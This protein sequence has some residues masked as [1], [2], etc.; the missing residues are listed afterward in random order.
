MAKRSGKHWTASAEAVNP[1]DL[2]RQASAVLASDPVQAE[3]L[4][5][6]AL[7]A[8]PGS[9]DARSVLGA[10][11]RRK[12]D[13]SAA[14]AVL[15][16]LTAAKSCPW[17]V[18]FELAQTRVALGQSRAAVAPLRKVVELNPHWTP[19][20]RLLGDILIAGGDFAG[21]QLAYDR[22]VR[23]M[24]RDQQLAAAADALI[25]DR[26]DDAE[27]ELRVL[28]AAKPATPAAAEHLLAE[29]LRRQ[30][31]LAQADRVLLRC[32]AKAPEFYHAR[33]SL[34]QVLLGQHRYVEAATELNRLL[35]RDPSDTH[36]LMLKATVEAALGRFDDVLALTGAVR[37]A[38]PDQARAWLVHANTLST[39]GRIA[40]AL[41][42]YLKVLELDAD[43][44]EAYWSLA[45]L[46]TFHFSAEQRADI[47]RLLGRKSMPSKDAAELNFA[48]AKAFE[49]DKAYA[50]AFQRY[51]RANAV[52]RMRRPYD[53]DAVS[54][55]FEKAK[56]VFTAEFFKL[57]SGWGV[58]DP[59]PI[60]IV[61][62]PRSGSTL[63]EQILASHP[64]I[65]GTRELIDLPVIVAG[66]GGY[67][68]S[69]PK[70]PAE[71]F[72]KMGREYL[73]RAAPQRHHERARFTDKR[74]FNFLN[75]GLIH[76]VLP[77]AK[78]VD[79]RRHP[80][81]CCV[82]NFR[83]H[84]AQ[85]FEASYDLEDLGRYYADYV[86]LMAHFD[87][88]LPGR[89]HR[90]IYEDLV[91]DTET[92]VK[93]LLT[94]LGV[95]FDPAC[96]RFFDNDR[97]VATPSSQQVRQPIFADALDQWRHFE[98]WLDPLKAALGPVLDAYPAAPT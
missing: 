90:V 78:I 33:V 34:A 1:A 40:E 98:P 15:T 76:L 86:D 26:C 62:M 82:S 54:E 45:N 5:R 88:T 59:D 19:A 65:E 13:P 24:I 42:A 83:Q 97:A 91:A 92:Q 81:A 21:A 25:A 94:Y 11:L 71:T 72:A 37:D 30:N 56:A 61:G 32:L 44:A 10:A 48:L 84:F 4:A 58:A 2:L 73:Q 55:R 31:K 41:E 69:V 80:L 23:S 16:R 53:R 38:F 79:V 3:T 12:G 9:V 35:E 96:L 75:A 57:R 36:C 18:H 74:P 47:E 60:F 6:Q 64:L 29:A 50:N 87:N 46:K 63:V 70:L 27:R 67:P 68:D 51:S 7:L 95:P 43:F 20:W 14:L 8:D 39:L 66:L 89:I 93:G 22:R 17:I 52:E 28:L 85:G 49:D 77:N